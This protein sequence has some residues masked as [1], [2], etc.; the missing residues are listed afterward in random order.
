[1][2][3][4]FACDIDGVLANFTKG[5]ST[6]CHDIDERFPVVQHPSE[7]QRWFWQNW[8]GADLQ[9]AKYVDEIV[10]Q[11]WRHVLGYPGFW[12]CLEPLISASMFDVLNDLGHRV[13]YITRRDGKNPYNETVSWLIQHGVREPLVVRVRSGQEKSSVM[14]DLGLDTIIEDSPRYTDLDLLPAGKRVIVIHYPYN[15]TCGGIHV[16]DLTSALSIVT[17]ERI[18][19]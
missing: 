11:T 13:V 3:R 9:D 12:Y 7:A 16:P 5:F 10:E 15:R 2:S 19:G 8:Y 6:I 4:A 18:Y 1:M 17:G 14:T